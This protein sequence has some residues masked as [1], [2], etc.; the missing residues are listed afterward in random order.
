MLKNG[1]KFQWIYYLY[2]LFL[3]LENF[4]QIVKEIAQHFSKWENKEIN[5]AQTQQV[6]ILRL[7]AALGYDIWNPFEIAA[8]PQLKGSVPDIIVY[9]QNVRLFVI[10]IKIFAK[11][12]TEQD[13][14]QAVNYVNPIGLRWAIITNGVEW[15]F[16]DNLKQAD[17]KEKCVLILNLKNKID[18]VHL[19]ELLNKQLWEN[20]QTVENEVA[21]LIEFIKLKAVVED[22]KQFYQINEPALARLI[23]NELN[24]EQQ[25]IARQHHQALLTWFLGEDEIISSINL[26][27]EESETFVA[28]T[29]QDLAVETIVSTTTER[30]ILE[31][32]SEQLYDKLINFKQRPD[33]GASLLTFLSYELFISWR[34]FYICLAETCIAFNYE[35]FLETK[36]TNT[37]KVKCYLLSNG[38]WLAVNLSQ[39]ELQKKIVRL[40]EKLEI[41]EKT[42]KL[43]YQNKDYFLP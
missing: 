34:I 26:K 15:H 11:K 8:Q 33:K 20:I 29:Q 4:K 24:P 36:E 6:I 7:L 40:L 31:E 30:R 42:F 25:K 9:C 22:Y 18:A 38:K 21:Q 5:E 43:V 10:E 28:K 16:L 13:Y 1:E 23:Q 17:S 39:V 3:V 19:F 27:V 14:K 12:F 32:F 37:G 35:N 2:R 41:P